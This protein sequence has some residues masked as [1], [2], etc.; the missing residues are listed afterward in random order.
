MR[1]KSQQDFYS[2]LMFLGVGI[3]FAWGATTYEIGSAAQMGPGYFPLLLGILTAI[4]G[5]AVTL[6][7]VVFET[8]GGGKIGAWA[9]RP[10]FLIIAANFTFGVLLGGL[11]SIHLPSS[12]L[13]LAIF[14]LTFIASLAGDEF[15]W[16]EVLVLA[17]VLTVASYLA[18][19]LLLHLQLPVW[20]AFITG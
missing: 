16:T 17:T 3:V 13:V 20:P 18:C 11:P 5:I 8:E 6:Q 4:L 7:S 9:W 19:V 15:K 1:I 14:A 2:G 10:L 12:G